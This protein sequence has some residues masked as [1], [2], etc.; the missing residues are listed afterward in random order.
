MS[1]VLLRGGRLFVDETIVTGDLLVENGLITAIGDVD[2]PDDVAEIVDLAGRTVLPGLIDCH[3]HSLFDGMD[4]TARLNEPYSLPYVRAARVLHDT[5]SRGITTVRDAG[6]A[7]LGIKRAV[8]SGLIDG[9]DMQIAVTILGETGGHSDGTTPAGLCNHLL[10]ATPGRPRGVVDGKREMRKRVRELVRSGAD[11]IKICTTGGVLSPSDSPKH[12]QFTPGEIRACVSEA[13]STERFVMAHA[14]G[15]EGILN[16]L[17]AGVRSIEHGI[18]ADDECFD[19]MKAAGAWLVP[20]LIAPVGLLRAIDR[21]AQVSPAVKAKAESVVAVHEAMLTAAVRA[22]VRIAFGSDAG[23]FPH[24][25]SLDELALME[26]SGMTPGQVL[27][28]ATRSSAELLG[29]SDRGR[30]APGL[31]ADLTIVEGDP[32]DFDDYGTRMYAVYTEGR[33]RR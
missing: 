26:R 1:T 11:V 25:E 28:A 30:L 19:E 17:R 13:A 4:E 15:R 29:L 14:Q 33:R 20:T 6:G 16:A 12:S 3:V 27:D 10:P 8:Q 32:L 21:G 24:A 22:G 2:A 5:L 9:P 31:R 7:D 18:Y 23:V